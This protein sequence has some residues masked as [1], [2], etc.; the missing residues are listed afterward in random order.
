MPDAAEIVDAGHGLHKLLPVTRGISRIPLETQRIGARSARVTPPGS[1]T[2]FEQRN[3]I[4]AGNA[5]NLQIQR[6][7]R[8][9]AAESM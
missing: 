8:I 5:G 9:M 4:A 2:G 3:A 6:T 1:E 7:A